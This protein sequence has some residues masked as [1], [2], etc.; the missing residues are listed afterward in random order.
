MAF[1]HSSIFS[2]TEAC[3]IITEVTDKFLLMILVLQSDTKNY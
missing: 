3:S 1:T 2:D